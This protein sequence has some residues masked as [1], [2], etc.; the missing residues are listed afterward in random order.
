[1]V[2]AQ[3]FKRFLNIALLFSLLCLIFAS[4]SYATNWF[5]RPDG[6][7]YG[8]E[9]GTDYDNAW[10]GLHE[11]VWGGSGVVAGD[12]LWVSGI[13]IYEMDVGT[14]I[15]RAGSIDLT[16]GGTSESARITIRGDPSSLDSSY[17]DGIIWGA[18]LETYDGTWSATGGRPGVYEYTIVSRIYGDWVFQV[19]DFAVDSFTVLDKTTSLNDCESTAGS[20]FTS[21]DNVPDPGDTIY[22]HMTDSGDPTGRILFS[23]FGYQFRVFS[24]N[25]ITFKNLT[26]YALR[27]FLAVNETPT[28]L[29]FEGCKFFYGEGYMFYVRDG[30]DYLEILDSE[31]AWAGNG[32]Y[33][34]TTTNEAPS[35]YNY[36]RNY[37]HDIGVRTSNQNSDAHPIGIQGG[38][39]GTINFNN[40]NNCGTGPL[41]YTDQNQELTNT[42]VIGNKVTNLHVLGSAVSYGV[43]TMTHNTAHVDRSG[44][45]FY[46][47]IVDTAEVCYRAQFED[48]QE[49]FNNVGVDCDKGLVGSR[50]KD[51]FVFEDSISNLT[52]RDTV[53]G[54]DSEAAMYVESVR[55][56]GSNPNIAGS[57]AYT[58][59]NRLIFEGGGTAELSI[60][61]DFVGATSGEDS[62]VRYINVSSGSWA[63]GDAAGE[64]YYTTAS[65][66][67]INNE[68]FDQV[69]GQ[70][71]I[72]TMVDNIS[73]PTFSSPENFTL[74]EVVTGSFLELTKIGPNIKARNNIFLDSTTN[75]VSYGTSGEESMYD[76]DYST[77]YPDGATMFS[78]SYVGSNNLADHQAG[79]KWNWV[80]DT[81][82][83]IADPV[84]DSDYRVTG[85]VGAGENQNIYIL[86]CEAVFKTGSE[87]GWFPLLPAGTKKGWCVDIKLNTSSGL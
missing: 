34:I 69:G 44:N 62:E 20:F 73:K 67:F 16:L 33:H 30:M 65:G 79:S 77:F 43:S 22:A 12:T 7:S 84:F 28:Y 50:S 45:R 23:R 40:I 52:F 55:Q 24:Y 59:L 60:G 38:T 85:T 19:D 35:Y 75:H 71:N 2:G 42:D 36:S 1:M 21:P 11:I 58:T 29:R 81:N 63:G 47:N 86:A 14:N 13:H 37:F 83:E 4:T 32:I 5:V 78:L 39:E 76:S 15:A 61:E 18:F 82:S 80:L 8:N 6:G 31:I 25:Y 74:N 27:S 53:I 26:F 70:E 46:G 49:V 41:L 51:I 54:V 72:L 57:F 10:D 64:L 56:S 66:A 68:N 3:I 17:V 87:P 48:E 9:D